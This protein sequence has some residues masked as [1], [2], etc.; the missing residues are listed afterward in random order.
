M[1][2]QLIRNTT[3]RPGDISAC[4]RLADA[5][6]EADC[7]EL[8]Y[9]VIEAIYTVLSEETHDIRAP[10]ID[11]YCEDQRLAKNVEP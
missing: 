8:A 3:L 11:R 5:L 6:H 4:A 1:L 9:R 7:D 2:S 10:V